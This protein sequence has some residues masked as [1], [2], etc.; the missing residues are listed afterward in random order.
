MKIQLILIFTFL[1]VSVFSQSLKQYV[2]TGNKAFKAG[3]YIEA[4]KMYKRA[5]QINNE[6]LETQYKYAESCR[7]LNEYKEAE[8]YYRKVSAT[9]ITSYP[10]SLFWLGEVLKNQG[11]YQKAQY[12][13]KSYYDKHATESDYYSLK[14]KH[15]IYSCEKAN[16]MMFDIKPKEIIKLDTVINSNYSELSSF[17]IDDSLLFYSSYRPKNDT[18]LRNFKSDIYVS[19]MQDSIWKS[20]ALIDTIINS[21]LENVS[22]VSFSNDKKSVYFSKCLIENEVSKLC[23]IYKAEFDGK[24]WSNIIELPSQINLQGYINTQPFIANTAEGSYLLFSSDRQG[25]FGK[26]DLWFAKIM[27]NGGYDLPQNIGNKINSVGDEITPYYSTKDSLL[28]FSSEWFENLGGFDIFKA[29]G[30]FYYW[31]KPENLGY[32]TNTTNN[33]LYYSQNSSNSKAYFTSNRKSEGKSE[34]EHCCNDIYYYKLPSLK[35]DSIVKEVEIKDIVIKDIKE[36]IP[37]TLYFHNDEPNPKTKDTITQFNYSYLYNNYIKMIDEYKREYSSNL[38][39]ETKSVAE[40]DIDEFFSNYVE[41]GYNKLELFA[42]RLEIL[43]AEGEN[44]II[45]LKGYTSPL[46]TAD[47]NSKLAKRRIYSLKNYFTEY[48]NGIFEKYL[49]ITS[50]KS[51]YLKFELQAIGEELANKNISDDLNDKRNSVYSPNAAMERKIQII[52]VSVP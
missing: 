9:N 27:Q 3:N 35:K 43:L 6:V 45:T 21:K 42:Q 2:R 51:N 25:G 37:I 47:Y 28:Y 10:L 17:E 23:K 15:E 12:A 26:K 32:P 38:K 20:S 1:F 16:L 5:I 52:A 7:M 18:L 29:K 11:Q 46:N 14:S 50:E 8:K 41:T 34:S 22:N 33:E 49:N 40:Y 31:S 13:Y 19:K 39:S 24:S 44:V 48:N 30:E 4:K 36:L